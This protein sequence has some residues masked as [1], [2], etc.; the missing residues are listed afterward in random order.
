MYQITITY[1]DFHNILMLDEVMSF[2]E[3]DNVEM[4]DWSDLDTFRPNIDFMI[5]L[6]AQGVKFDDKFLVIPPK[7]PTDN[8]LCQRLLTRHRNGYEISILL[9]L[10]KHYPRVSY[11]DPDQDM[12]L[13]AEKL[14]NSR[15]PIWY[16]RGEDVFDKEI[17]EKIKADCIYPHETVILTYDQDQPISDSSKNWCLSNNWKC[18][19]N[20]DIT[21]CEA[22]CVV[23][24]ECNPLFELVS[25]A[26]NQIIFVSTY[27]LV[28]LTRLL[29]F[30]LF[31]KNFYYF[32]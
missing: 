30:I 15:I 11:L 22:Q 9:E 27:G 17:L 32:Q 19:E 24:F 14:P 20:M 7:D 18:T 16:Q 26:R 31:P 21:G 29:I 12:E 2:K 1:K 13:E 8:T 28:D 6:S 25:R 23:I 10:L 3:N 5:A 4:A